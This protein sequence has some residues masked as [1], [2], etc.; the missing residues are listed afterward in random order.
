MEKYSGMKLLPY[1]IHKGD[2]LICLFPLF[3]RQKGG[4]KLLYS[5]PMV[6]ITYIPYL[7]Y[8]MSGT[9]DGLRQHGKERYLE[10]VADDIG[11]VTA[12]LRPNFT[13]ISTPPRFMDVRSFLWAGYGVKPQFNYITDLT[14]SI[15]DI[16]N[17]FDKGLKKSIRSLEKTGNALEIVAA[18]DPAAM[19][20]AMRKKLERHGQT[21]WHCQEPG[22]SRGTPGCLPG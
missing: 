5:P 8:I 21:F 3:Y 12:K 19:F 17:G 20:A 22:L 9:Y 7:G 15:E 6:V 18:S 4:L 1:G 14:G 13:S 10:I 2:E 16:W 11:K